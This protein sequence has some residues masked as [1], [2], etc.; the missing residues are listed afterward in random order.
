MAVRRGTFTTLLT[1]Q[2]FNDVVTT[3]F[4][5]ALPMH[6]SDKVE[7]EVQISSAGGGSHTLQLIPQFS[8][9]GGQEFA[10]ADYGESQHIRYEAADVAAGVRK[11]YRMDAAG[12]IVRFS[13][14]STS[15][16]STNTFTVTIK[17]RGLSL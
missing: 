4:S 8:N 10:D 11:C 9:D 6:L 2:V 1:A 17:C 14:I 3:A 15:T 16:T 7:F 12:E 13:L 5:T